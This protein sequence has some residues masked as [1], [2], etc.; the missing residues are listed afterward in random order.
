MSAT[1]HHIRA[2]SEELTKLQSEV[3][4]LQP[5]VV[6]FTRTL[7]EAIEAPPVEEQRPVPPKRGALFLALPQGEV[8]F[9]RHPLL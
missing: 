8:F 5:Q 6:T 7:W 3:L 4:R 9:T 1:I 2:A